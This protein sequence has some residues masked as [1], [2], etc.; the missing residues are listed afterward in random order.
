[1]GRVASDLLGDVPA[2]QPGAGLLD[3]DHGSVPV[4]E[5]AG[6]AGTVG[7]G[8]GPFFGS[9]FIELEPEKRVE[10]VL[11]IVLVDDLQCRAIFF[12]QTELPGDQV[13]S[14]A[15][16]PEDIEGATLRLR[17]LHARFLLSLRYRRHRR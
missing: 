1:M 9:D 15:D 7:I 17:A 14:G 10:Q 16:P 3:H 2:A 4:E 11:K 5:V 12:S 13:K 8:R 6:P